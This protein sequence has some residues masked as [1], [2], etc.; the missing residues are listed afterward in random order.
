MRV[1]TMNKKLVSMNVELNEI[2]GEFKL[3]LEN[4]IRKQHPS[5]VDVIVDCDEV[6]IQTGELLSNEL[7]ESVQNEFFLEL[8]TGELLR[9]ADGD[10]LNMTYIFKHK[11]T[12]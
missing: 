3:K 6:L 8:S 1:Q 2:C 7:L 4:F 11:K 12:V 9:N 10:I 5:R